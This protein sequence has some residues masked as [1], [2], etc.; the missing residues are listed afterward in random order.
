MESQLGN[1]L[2]S[3]IPRTLAEESFHIKSLL[4]F[5]NKI[6]CFREPLFCLFDREYRRTF[7]G[8]ADQCRSN[9]C[10]ADCKISYCLLFSFRVESWITLYI[11]HD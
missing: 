11:L 7:F 6:N 1:K 8:H 5:G 2:A 9:N 3:L 4:V 10:V